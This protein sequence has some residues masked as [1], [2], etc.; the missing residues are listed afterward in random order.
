MWKIKM[1]RVPAIII[2]GTSSNAGKTSLTLGIV[3]ALRKRG[4]KV[5]PFKVGPDFLDPLYLSIA[6]QRTSYNL[7]GWMC[8]LDYVNRQ[9]HNCGNDADIIVIEG[10]MG[11]FDGASVDSLRGSTAEIAKECEIPV[12]LVGEASGV[13]RSFAATIHGFST[14]EKGV[15]IA[16]VIANRVGSA[17]HG[18]LLDNALQHMNLPPL[19]GAIP[20]NSLPQL[21]SRHL[22]LVS[23]NLQ[24]FTENDCDALA[25]ACEEYIDIDQLLEVAKKSSKQT[26]AD[27]KPEQID[28]PKIKLAVADDEAFHFA[29][30]DN[31]QALE[32]AGAEIIRFSPLK[33]SSLPENIDALY[34][35]GG[36]PELF[37]KELSEN[38]SMLTSLSDFA[39]AGNAVYAECG[40]LMYLGE[41]IETADGAYELCAVAPLSTQML[42]KRKMLGYTEVTLNTDSHFGSKGTV[43]RGHE[44]H[45]SE[46][47]SDS[48]EENGW[49]EIYDTTRRRGTIS[50]T[51]GYFKENI[52]V[53]YVHLHWASK[54]DLARSFI[55]FCMKNR[56]NDNE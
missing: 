48:L 10:V 52:L 39:A 26:S 33:D 53:S 35:P 30:P 18:K 43:I 29:Y 31:I 56:R 36:Y 44:F 42:E 32:S 41:K 11:L 22:G 21:S 6:A 55:N 24:N 16:G 12:L 54:S 19:L 4:L 38:K 34:I 50:S 45:Y 47:T 27:F 49:K 40:G 37:A 1:Q 5:Q 9:I 51:E 3:A 17:G 14:F 23:A 8:G 28:T 25:E 13:A 20:N 7:D 2:G 46:I 15:E